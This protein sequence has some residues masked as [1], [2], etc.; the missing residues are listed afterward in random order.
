MRRKSKN[1]SYIH[2]KSLFGA[3][4]RLE[5]SL[6]L[7]FFENEA[8]DAVTVNGVTLRNDLDLDD[9]WFQQDGAT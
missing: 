7:F 2:E 5:E 3:L 8:G 1:N 4:Y 9:V 6:H